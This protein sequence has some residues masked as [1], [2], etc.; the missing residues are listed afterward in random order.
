M[1]NELE[2]A[3]I[4]GGITPV[5]AKL[6]GVMLSI[7]LPLGLPQQGDKSQITRLQNK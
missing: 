7:T 3:L 2:T 4:D 6:H 5:A 1:A